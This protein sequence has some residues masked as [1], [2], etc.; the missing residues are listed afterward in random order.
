MN[1]NDAP[2]APTPPVAGE[3]TPHQLARTRPLPVII[4]IREEKQFLSGHITGAK[5]ITRDEL[6]LKLT[7]IAPGLATPILVY[8][9]V[10]NH[11][12]LAAEKLAQM[13]YRNV[14]SLIG[15]LQSWL[16]AGGMV[17]CPETGSLAGTH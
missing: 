6:E 4:D 8:C 17:E 2:F 1:G 5:H 7:G 16:E 10:G 13:G 11:A 12:P 9:A 14:S 15:G 3:M